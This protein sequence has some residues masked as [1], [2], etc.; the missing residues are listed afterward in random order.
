MLRQFLSFLDESTRLATFVL[1]LDDV[2]WSDPSTVDLLAHLSRHIRGMRVLVIVTYRPSEMLLG[3]H[4]F[5]RLKMEMQG[6]GICKELTLGLLNVEEVSL[7]IRLAF[8]QNRFPVE[9]AERVYT[10]TDGNPLFVVELLRYLCERGMLQE[11]DGQWST[12]QQLSDFPRDLP[13]SIRGMIERMLDQLSESDRRVLAMASVQGQQFD[14]AFVAE[15]LVLP[16]ADVE[17]Q[18]VALANVHG[19]IRLEREHELPDGVLNQR[20]RF[21]HALFQ[22]ALA[23]SLSPT[24]RAVFALELAKSQERHHASDLSA[25]ASELAYLNESGR[26]YSRAAR[27]FYLAAQNASLVFA[28]QE[29]ATLARRG[30]ELL[31]ALPETP[32]RAALEFPLQV[33]RGQQVQA[34]EGFTMREAEQ[35]FHRA[36]ELYSSVVVGPEP[37][38][39]VLCGLFTLY[40]VRSDL[41]KAGAVAEE[42]LKLGR[43]AH[44]PAIELQGHQAL[45][46][47]ALSRGNPNLALE[48]SDRAV[49]LC[50]PEKI[51]ADAFMFGP[52]PR[53]VAKSYSWLALWL[54]GRPEEAQQ[55]CDA[56]IALAADLAPTS[57]VMAFL[58]AAILDHF[59]GDPKRVCQRS[60]TANEIAREHGMRWWQAWGSVLRGWSLAMGGEPE[61]VDL[62]RTALSNLQATGSQSY[63]TYH[64]GLLAEA[65]IAQ[66]EF[67]AGH[68]VLDDALEVVAQTGERFWEA[69]LYRLRGELWLHSSRRNGDAAQHAD[70]DIR[71]AL[72][73]AHDQGA[74]SLELRAA[75]GLAKLHRETPAAFEDAV[76]R[77]T[78]VYGHFTEGLQTVDAI[79][80]ARLL[81]ERL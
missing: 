51:D 42:L 43:A 38:A 34:A 60:E 63:R 52:D 59:R 8:P 16:G 22:S 39:Q 1:W 46:V 4:P 67:E 10:R 12:T 25:V 2:H 29:A 58:F 18:L 13:E 6:R 30:L 45:G 32:E 20:Y 57:Q 81:R 5:R 37:L 35:A 61:G 75:I 55:Q 48:C 73:I 36:R 17:E 56:A 44:D 76:R 71:M 41:A 40:K 79:E 9:M 62:M 28:H 23:G 80:A 65:V 27:Y 54:S 68:C 47:T 26:D 21:V 15:A 50:V 53:A 11:I 77:L 49:A 64:L 70:R 78:D 66:H 31:N 24:R 74:R 7:Y 69:E 14:S 72:R 19:L 3:M 33:M